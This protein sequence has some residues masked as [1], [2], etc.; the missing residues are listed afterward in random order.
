[1]RCYCM[2][3]IIFIYLFFMHESHGTWAW[4]NNDWSFGCIIHF[5]MVYTFLWE[6]I[7]MENCLASGRYL[8]IS[9]SRQASGCE[10]HV[11]Q[12]KPCMSAMLLVLTQETA[13]R[14]KW[15]E[16]DEEGDTALSDG[17]ILTPLWW[18]NVAVKG[19]PSTGCLEEFIMDP[20]FDIL[21]PA[22]SV[23]LGYTASILACYLSI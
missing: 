4:V 18:N 23:S 16:E 11:C 17:I 12:K 8:Y 5:Y 13:W 9:Y 20:N 2:E 15:Q 19:A 10:V 21:F 22:T 7:N 6:Y 14:W 1:M 3:I